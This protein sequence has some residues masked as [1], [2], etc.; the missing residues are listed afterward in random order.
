VIL[1]FYILLLILGFSHSVAQSF[2]DFSFQDTNVCN[3][4]VLPSIIVD[5]KRYDVLHFEVDDFRSNM[6]GGNDVRPKWVG[7]VRGEIAKLKARYLPQ[8]DQQMHERFRRILGV[9][10]ANKCKSIPVGL[11]AS[12]SRGLIATAYTLCR[13]TSALRLKKPDERGL[14]LSHYAALSNNCQ[15]MVLLAKQNL[16]LDLKRHQENG[17]EEENAAPVHYAARCGSI[18]ALCCLLFL[19]CNYHCY[20]SNGWLPIHHAAAFN[21][22]ASLKIL[23]MWDEGLKETETKSPDSFT[24][25]LLASYY[26]AIKVFSYL[27]EVRANPHAMDANGN[28]I[29]HLA[30]LREHV[31]IL[32]WLLDQQKRWMP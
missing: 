4:D 2:K 3:P 11:Q 15:A 12:V 20:D 8:S 22:L 26:G 5:G 24:P 29:V 28:S 1:F 25:L 13:R 32:E 30:A 31:H 19:K 21:Q 6:R 18:D 7:V 16:Q 14:L 10:L 23:L 17:G 9:K 27:L